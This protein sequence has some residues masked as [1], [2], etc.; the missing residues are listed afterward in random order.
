M[1][2]SKCLNEWNTI[3]EALGQGKQTILIRKYTTSLNEFLLYPTKSYSFDDNY[4]ESF[5]KKYFPF[6]QKNLI[7]KEEE[8]KTEV[9]YYAKIEPLNGNHTTLIGKREIR[10]LK[11]YY[12]WTPKHVNAYLQGK[13]GHLWILRVYK[14]KN[15]IMEK[16]TRGIRYANLINA[17]S[18]K[19]IIPAMDENKFDN[20]IEKLN[21]FIN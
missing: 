7:P 13:K 21:N 8:K 5:Q 19:E 1:S 12:I 2:I 11:D 9:K 17:T 18:V 10:K 16:R 14:L 4:L 15:P 20:F 3:I 6:V